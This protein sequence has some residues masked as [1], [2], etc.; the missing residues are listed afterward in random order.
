MIS[1]NKSTSTLNNKGVI[2]FSG[3]IH[4]NKTLQS[5][6]LTGFTIS[7]DI[8]LSLGTVISNMTSLDLSFA[9]IG[10][11]GAL[12]IAEALRG[13][14]VIKSG[15][16]SKG[17]GKKVSPAVKS[18]IK[19]STNSKVIIPSNILDNN[20]NK[21]P[22]VL[23]KLISLN[24]R[25]NGI[26]SFAGIEIL[27]SLKINV[28][29]L[30]HLNLSDNDLEDSFLD[31]LGEYFVNYSTTLVSCEIG[32]NNYS[33]ECVSKFQRMT[34]NNSQIISLGERFVMIFLF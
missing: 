1:K 22:K 7:S 24:L 32:R 13:D 9:F 27:N 25:S 2:N 18:P 23:N 21:K 8:L 12:Y 31:A 5:I 11:K 33:D 14:V 20:F 15:S 3:L 19:K 26:S 29:S 4:S 6:G 34:K 28:T 10:T 30:M 17:S 16:N